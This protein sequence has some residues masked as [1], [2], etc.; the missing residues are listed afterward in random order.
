LKVE[1]EESNKVEDIL[2]QQIKEKKQEC[3]KLE[4]EVVYLKKKLEKAQTEL[5]INIQKIKVSEKLD[6]VLILKGLHS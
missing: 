1:L 4:E 2:L 5:N 3:E 6:V